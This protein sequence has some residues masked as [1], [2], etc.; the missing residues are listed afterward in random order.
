VGSI[1]CADQAPLTGP[2]RLAAPAS[3]LSCDE[4]STVVLTATVRFI[5]D[6][7]IC[8]GPNDG[9]ALGHLQIKLTRA[10]DNPDIHDWSIT[11][12]VAKRVPDILTVS[13][14]HEVIDILT[15]GRTV[16]PVL[17]VI[18]P[19][20]DDITRVTKLIGAGRLPADVAERM[21]S[22]ANEFVARFTLTGGGGMCGSFGIDNPEI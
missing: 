1:A 9:A 19:S 8:P 5:E 16:T 21:I 3:S 22:A 17:G 12:D 10:I 14:N 2:A 18:V 7:E 11:G 20:E 6:P 15:G 4:H 13:V